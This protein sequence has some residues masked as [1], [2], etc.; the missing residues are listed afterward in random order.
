MFSPGISQWLTVALNSGGLGGL[1]TASI[2][3][4]SIS[5]GW[6]SLAPPMV[7]GREKGHSQSTAGS[8]GLWHVTLFA[9]LVSSDWALSK[10]SPA[11]VGG[12]RVGSGSLLNFLATLY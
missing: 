10:G 1:I 4:L 2:G 8:A 3:W 6:G 11:E 5:R 12:S 9:L 7:P